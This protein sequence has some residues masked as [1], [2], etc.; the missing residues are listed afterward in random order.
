[1]HCSH[2]LH[3]RK[4]EA[5][6]LEN[7]LSGWYKCIFLSFII[8]DDF[9]MLKQFALNYRSK[10]I[11]QG[12]SEWVCYTYE[13]KWH[14]IIQS[15]MP[16]LLPVNKLKITAVNFHLICLCMYLV[17]RHHGL[18]SYSSSSISLSRDLYSNISQSLM[19]KICTAN[20]AH[21]L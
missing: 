2:N 20:T 7:N 9:V 18:M 8:I 10:T 5:A 13:I 6:L 4:W 12:M 1:M 14:V 19:K 3:L 15:T 16:Q 11:H 17:V 21:L